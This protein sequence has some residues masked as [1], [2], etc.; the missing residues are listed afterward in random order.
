M[1]IRYDIHDS[2]AW[3]GGRAFGMWALAEMGGEILI[4]PFEH[5]GGRMNLCI[6][7]I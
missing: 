7:R 1:M 2:M 5:G 4:Y 6:T 3:G